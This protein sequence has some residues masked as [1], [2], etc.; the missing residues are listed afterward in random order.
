MKA[1]P[2][3]S[4]TRSK[5]SARRSRSRDDRDFRWFMGRVLGVQDSVV[6]PSEALAVARAFMALPGNERAQFGESIAA[7]AFDWTVPDTQPDDWPMVLRIERDP[8]I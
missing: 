6:L 5:I 2:D 4:S 7:R 3:A 8:L 1:K